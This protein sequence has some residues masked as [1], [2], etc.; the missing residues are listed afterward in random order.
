MRS[1]SGLR[2]HGATGHLQTHQAVSTEDSGEEGAI[3]GKGRVVWCLDG[4]DELNM[5]HPQFE[6]RERE[7]SLL[8]TGKG[9]R[10]TRQ[11]HVKPSTAGLQD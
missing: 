11:K 7:S 6:E 4:W 10:E 2:F 9:D 1:Q 8:G 3:H 5:M